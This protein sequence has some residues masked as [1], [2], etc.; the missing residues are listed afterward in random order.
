MSSYS[1]SNLLCRIEV[2]KNVAIP[3]TIPISAQIRNN[4]DIL[5]IAP[6]GPNKYGV[7]D[8]SA[9]DIVKYIEENLPILFFGI[10]V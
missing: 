1:R 7:N 4:V 9:I 3:M 10:A 6:I 2:K 8:V 5:N